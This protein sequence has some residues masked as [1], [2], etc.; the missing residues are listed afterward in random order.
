MRWL[1]S[2]QALRPLFHHRAYADLQVFQKPTDC[3]LRELA[4]DRDVDLQPLFFELTLQTT[5]SFALGRPISRDRACMSTTDETFAEMF[6]LAQDIIAK[7]LRLPHLHWLIGGSKLRNA[8]QK[9]QTYADAMIRAGSDHDTGPCHM[10]SDSVQHSAATT[11]DGDRARDQ[12]INIL[13]AGRDTT[14]C[15]LSW[16]L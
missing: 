11:A 2:R 6:D 4:G 3:L 15:L 12:A 10:I 5:K 14:A 8:C 13:L 1:Q 16:T 9:I 7:R